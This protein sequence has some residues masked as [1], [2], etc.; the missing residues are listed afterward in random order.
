MRDLY[1]IQLPIDLQK[2]IKDELIKYFKVELDLQDENVEQ[3][4]ELAMSSRVGD[5]EDT[6]NIKKIIN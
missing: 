1:I 5:L 3:E 2:K 4:L 6:I